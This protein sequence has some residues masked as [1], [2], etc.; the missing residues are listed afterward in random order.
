[1]PCGASAPWRPLLRSM[2]MPSRTESRRRDLLDSILASKG[3][4]PT[5]RGA[6]EDTS[7]AQGTNGWNLFGRSIIET[8]EAGIA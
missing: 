4:D 5:R 6:G 8:L 2:S 7:P 3:M 1:M